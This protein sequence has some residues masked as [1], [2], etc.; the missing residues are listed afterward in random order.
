MEMKRMTN[1]E[2]FETFKDDNVTIR[3]TVA[4]GK[5]VEYS[6]KLSAICEFVKIYLENKVE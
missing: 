4:D 3:K 5:E 2:I 6:L 1:E